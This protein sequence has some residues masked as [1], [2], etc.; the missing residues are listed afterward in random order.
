ME[1]SSPLKKIVMAAV[2]LSFA[3]V[4][5][6][7]WGGGGQIIL[8]ADSVEYDQARGFA[9]AT[10][11]VRMSRDILRVFAP[12]IEYDAGQQTIKAFSSPEGRVVLLQGAQRLEGDHLDLDM[13]SGEGVL[14]SAKGRFPAEKGEIFASGSDVTTMKIQTARDEGSA[15]GRIPAGVREGGRV[16]RWNSVG[17]TTCPEE[18]PH[19]QLVSDRLVIIPG[20]RITAS[21][22]KVYIGGRYLLTYPFDYV[23]ELA[24]GE[25]SR[26]QFMP[27]VMYE[28]EKGVGVSFGA[29]FM[30]GDISGRWKAFL[31]SKVDFEGALSLEHRFSDSVRLFAEGDY[32]WNSDQKEKRF[33]PQWGADYDFGGWR[34]RLWWSQA[35]SVTVERALGDTFTGTLWRKPEFSLNSPSWKLPGSIGS[36]SLHGIWGEYETTSSTGSDTVTIRRSGVG[37][38]VSGSSEHGSIRPFWGFGYWGYDYGSDYD[39]QEVTNA[40]FGLIWPAGPLTMTSTWKRQWV[41]GGSPMSWDDYSESEAFYQKIAIPLGEK[42]KLAVRGGYN[43]KENNLDEMFYRL[44]FIGADCYRVDLSYRDDRTGDDSW[45]GVTFVI[46]AFPSHPFFLGSK[47][48]QEYG[49]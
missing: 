17:I 13:I 8:D 24:D 7:A 49:E 27:R 38:S 45:A 12:R 10:G 6:T 5:G 19:Y 14:T 31:W 39:T 21:K 26:S 34:G 1:R 29:P 36:I 16:F 42:W 41:D 48:I 47:E 40:H 20:Y 37:G 28:G 3:A 35:E 9:V 30:I 32:S 33:R 46:N 25:G 23:V 15:K 22:P 2:I 18:N 4:L 43:L 44:S 11:N